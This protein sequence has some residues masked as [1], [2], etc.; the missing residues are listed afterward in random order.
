MFN[1][2]DDNDTSFRDMITLMLS[3]MVVLIMVLIVHIG[4]NATSEKTK[5]ST[6][7]GQVSVEITWDPKHNSDVDL[8][9]QGPGD[10]PVGYSNKG[11]QLFNLLRDD[12][13]KH[14]D[15][16]DVNF[17]I[18]Y[19]RGLVAGEYTVNVHWYAN[20]SMVA[21]EPVS[22]VVSTKERD[23]APAIQVLTTKVK[24]TQEGQE[25][26]AFRFKLDAKG[27]VVPGSVH[28]VFKPLRSGTQ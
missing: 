3:G 27:K 19:T 14:A 5:D 10:V 26:T 28:H 4:K 12:L 2:E 24:L 1:H 9:V 22:V 21:D 17:E 11:G 6:A 20:K 23:D 18:S 16:S 25:L 7:P 15:A 13:G 8:W